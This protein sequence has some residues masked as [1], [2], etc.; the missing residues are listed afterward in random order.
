VNLGKSSERVLALAVAIVGVSAAA[1]SG[2][3]AAEVRNVVLVTLDT[4]RADALG[5]YGR[6][7]SVTPVLDAFARESVRYD[8]AHTVAPLTL[9]AHASML[10]GL[11][12]LRHSLRDN[13]LW[14]LPEKALSVAELATKAG[15]DTA[16]FVSSSVLDRAFGL[17]SGF[18]RYE[19]PVRGATDATSRFSERGAAETSRA[20]SKWLRT[21]KS[22]EP[23]LLWVHFFDPHVPYAAPESF[24][25]QAGGNAYLAEVA[26]VDQAVG[27]LLAVLD[28]IG[29]RGATLVIVAADHGESLGEHGEPTHGVFCYEATL[30]VPLLVRYPDGFGAGSAVSDPVSVADLAPTI[31]EALNLGALDADGVS[32]FRRAPP[33]QRGLYFECY[34]G[35]LDYGWSPI[36]GWLAGSM[37]YVASSNP[38]LY[39]LRADRSEARNLLP[40]REAERERFERGIR[41]IA[42][43]PALARDDGRRIDGALARE[44][45][46][47]GY[48]GA[49]AEVGEL[50]GPLERLDL[51]SPNARAAELNA[52]LQATALLEERSFEAAAPMLEAITRS[53]PRNAM[54]WDG[55]GFALMQLGRFDEA[56]DALEQRLALP[57]RV[58]Q[59]HL[60]LGLCF[61]QI[62]SRDTAITHL[63]A[64]LALDPALA[65]A[66]EALTRLG[67]K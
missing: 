58:P 31:A 19:A 59:T 45:A 41:E 35:Y 11:V 34:S 16:A 48:A 2:G 39:D 55:F 44:L 56:R 54:A 47:L 32:L 13:G 52:F 66:R 20:A 65:E 7:P 49:G 30:R 12:P 67:A 17:D 26:Y 24:V 21:R 53:N 43:R 28:E 63:R 3:E 27:E 14:P 23:F 33:E 38:E 50:P 8:E 9:P 18:A 46:S 37:K 10:T 61:E 42:A 25:R 5:C 4:T 1:C 57:S 62:G 36:A 40:A 6:A 29:E 15:V 60:N 22:S 51:P 64:A